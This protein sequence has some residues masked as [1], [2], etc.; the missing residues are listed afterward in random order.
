[1]MFLFGKT[2]PDIAAWVLGFHRVPIDVALNSVRTSSY[3][4]ICNQFEFC[5]QGRC[6]CLFL[7]M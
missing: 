7:E 4:G 3:L 2:R 5:Q 1:M 6:V